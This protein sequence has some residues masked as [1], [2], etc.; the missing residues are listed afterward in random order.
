MANNNPYEKEVRS[1]VAKY[2]QWQYPDVIYRFDLAADQKL[3]V[4]QA[5]RN[6]KLH[7]LTGYPDM[8]VAQANEN[9]A[10]LFLELKRKGAGTFLK[11]GNLS[12]QDHIQ[13]QAN[14]LEKLKDAGYQA[15]FSVGIENTE[16]NLDNYL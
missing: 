8:F 6:S 5:K 4:G 13:K 14:I 11:D 7:N 2:M 10:G 15:K 12:S 16:E 9:Y 1:A 3:T